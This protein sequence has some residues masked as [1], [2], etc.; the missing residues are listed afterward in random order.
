MSTHIYTNRY[1]LIYAA[2]DLLVM[3]IVLHVSKGSTVDTLDS[4]S[5]LYLLDGGVVGESGDHHLL[6]HKRPEWRVGDRV[7][8]L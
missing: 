1:V 5:R 2:T 3:V 4:I 7:D 8:Y 6:L